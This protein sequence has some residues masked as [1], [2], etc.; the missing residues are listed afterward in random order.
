MKRSKEEEKEKQG[1]KKKQF[2]APSS[3]SLELLALHKKEEE[4]ANVVCGAALQRCVSC[5]AYLV[6]RS[7]TNKQTK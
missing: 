7:S 3:Y 6:Q 4:E 1:N 5:A 2:R